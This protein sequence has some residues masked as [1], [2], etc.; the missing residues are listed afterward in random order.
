MDKATDILS[1][2][3]V[4]TKYAKYDPA[5]QR[6]ETWE[7]IVWRNIMMHIQKY[8]HLDTKIAS[9]YLDYVMPKKILPSMRSLQFGGEPIFKSPNRVFN[10][11]YLPAEQTSVFQETMFLLLG[12]SG[13]GYSVQ[14]RHVDQLPA[15]QGPDYR[16]RRFLVGDSIEGWADAVKVLME[17]YFHG[18]IRPVF[19]FSDIRP[20]GASLIT[21]GGKAPGPEPLQ[22]CLEQLES[23][24]VGIMSTRGR[25]TKMKP[26]EVHDFL[27]YIADAVLAGGIR[28]AALIC[29]FDR[30]DDE[31]LECKSG[32]WYIDNPQRGRAN[33]SAVLPRADVTKDEFMRL[34]QKVEDSGAGEPGVYWTNDVDWGTNP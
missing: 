10:C 4:F 20:K 14:R 5:K 16:E 28:R 21:S 1:Q 27:C 24:L 18:K 34:M 23:K 8:P 11:A 6:R 25:G 31:M 12:G 17:S 30:D 26:I 32:E 3:T 29:L 19:D 13:A 22:D 33:N 7:E 2:L 15:L 9:V